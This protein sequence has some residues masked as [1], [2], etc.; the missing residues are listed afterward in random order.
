MDDIEEQ[1]T[2]SEPDKDDSPNA[3]TSVLASDP[4]PTRSWQDEEQV[5]PKNHIPLVFFALLLTTFL[6]ALDE[7][8]VATALPTIVADL[9]GGKDYSWVGSAYLLATA[10][11]SPLYG[12]VSDLVGRK[13]V[14]YPIIVLFLIGSALCGAAQN[15]TWLIAA[16]A[17]QGI[18]GGGILQ[19]VNIV[20]GDIVPLEKRGTFGG[21]TGALWGIASIVGPLVGGALS[22]HASWRWCFWINLPT[23]GIAL[24]LLVSSL[25]FNPLQNDKSFRQHMAEFDFQGLVLLITGVV[26]LLL[27]FNQGETSWKSPATITL[28]IVGGA[29]LVIAAIWECFTSRSP[30]IP[31]RL[32]RTRTTAI[33]LITVFLHAFAFFA[34]SYYLPVY[35]Q[36][37]GASATLAGV[38]ML[39]FCLGACIASFI[40]GFLVNILGDVRRIMA[41]SFAVMTLGFGLMTLLTNTSSIATQEIY[42]LISGIGFGGLF[43]PPVTATVGLVRQLGS[44][45]GVSVGQAIWTSEIRRRLQGVPGLN[46]DTSS[47]G[48]ADSVRELKNIQ[49]ISLRNLVQHAY[50]KSIAVIWILDTP[51]LGLSFIMVLFMKHYSLKRKFVQSDEESSQPR[52]GAAP[53]SDTDDAHASRAADS[54]HDQPEANDEAYIADQAIESGRE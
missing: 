1:T 26:C 4:A 44:T 22:D 28:L 25:H 10:A 42:P 46:I 12:K 13:A 37:L 11:M 38:K 40:V 33:I 32:F 18:G 31:P 52:T 49:P 43:F 51:L 17:I 54:A 39:P 9:R 41:V 35:Y 19:M 36:A 34:A 29:V 53:P 2:R 7:T 14:L 20:I 45:I 47:S 6:A 5:L 24:A 3:S 27:G 21:Y 16:R 8:I 23:G 48:I 30:I 15:M 50:T